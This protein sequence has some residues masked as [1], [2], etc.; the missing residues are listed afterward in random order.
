MNVKLIV[1]SAPSGAGKTTI[2][3]KL[4]ERYPG[5]RFSV[6]CTTRPRRSYEKHSTDYEFISDEEFKNRQKAGA[7]LEYEEVHGY[8]YGTPTA[9][10]ESSLSN[11]TV[12]I[13]EVDVNGALTIKA[14]Y[15]GE[16][17][18][19]FV[20]PPSMESLKVRLRKRG[21]DSEERI[22]ERLKR[23]NMEMEKSNQFDLEVVNEN[24]D[25]VVNEIALKLEQM[26]GGYTHVS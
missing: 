20:H 21:S 6:S 15:P 10:V 2:A 8:M 24:L 16:S 12:L 7:L 26:N 1:I 23:V 17:V 18:T 9:V 22:E 5:W 13:L 4:Q 14:A 19:V 3:R 11:G 25:E